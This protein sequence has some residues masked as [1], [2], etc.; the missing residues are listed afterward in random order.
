[1][2]DT[3][4]E[5]ANSLT[6]FL[7]TLFSIVAFL[8]LFTFA[9]FN[10]TLFN[11]LTFSVF[12]ISLIFVYLV[13]TLYHAVSSSNVK[14]KEFLRKLDQAMI[15]LLIPATYTPFAV[16][17]LRSTFGLTLLGSVWILAL[18]GIVLRFT[19]KKLPWWFTTTSYFF[20]AGT[21]VFALPL[22]IEFITFYGVVWL[23]AGG[24]FYT[25][26]AT[27]FGIELLYP[28]F[29]LTAVHET[30]HVLVM[31]GSFCHF[32]VILNYIL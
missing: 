32:W 21:A 27:L 2:I 22:V 30:F 16:I 19:A 10:G 15:Y 5:P 18:A 20:L 28:N 14:L 6:H 25:V 9:L 17:L 3:L 12:G 4:D 8:V 29:R 26:G 7:G 13:S 31:F 1:M 23:I 11:I 24:V